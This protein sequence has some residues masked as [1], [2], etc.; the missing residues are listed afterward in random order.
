MEARLVQLPSAAEPLPAV[1]VIEDRIV[2]DRL[3]VSDP[4]LAA[5]LRERPAEDRTV[6]VER[7]LRIGLLALQDA[8]VTVNVDVVRGEFEKLARQN[9]QTNE[10]AALALEQTLRT[11]FADGDGRL[12]RTLEKFLGDRGALRTMVEELFD[13][14]KRDSAIGRIGRMLE[15]YFDGDASKLAVLLDPT[16]MNSPMHQF[17]QEITAG[18]KSLNDR[19]IAIEVAAAARAT[20]RSKSAA[21][22]GDFED[23]VEALLG[24]LARGAG[25]LL[26]RTVDEAG[27]TMR[28]KKGD[29]V[30]TVNPMLAR[31]ADL[32]VVVEAKDR[33]VSGREMREELREA[34]T[35]RSA[36]VALVVFTPA[37]APT[38]IAP[39]DVRAGDVYCVL[40]PAAPDLSTLE[41]AVRLAR[42]LAVSSLRETEAEVDSA[43]IGAALSGI[44]EQLDVI[45][46]LKAQLTSISGAA[47]GVSTGLDRLRDNVIARV[48]EAEAELAAA[49][50]K[51]G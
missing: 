37:H 35:N 23:L 50:R 20:E 33:K 6:I 28:S 45:K 21:K 30:L 2:V 24:E 41:V 29:F 39:F 48:V 40:D 1:R 51:A 16:R 32:R 3:T 27:A 43:A 9:E 47:S 26:D 11:N 44:R 14:K 15:K 42:L 5:Y 49:P 12:P 46:G 13:E 7:A 17:R 19:L 10:R 22:G 18:F 36:A 34:K 25:D 38:G 31:G 8:G 4:A